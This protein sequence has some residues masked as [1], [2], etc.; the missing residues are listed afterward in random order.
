MNVRGGNKCMNA[1][2]LRAFQ[3][4]P[5]PVDIKLIGTRQSHNH[6]TADLCCHSLDGFKI[7]AGGDRKTGLQYVHSQAVELPGHLQLIFEVHTA[8]GGLF[9]V[10]QRGVKDKDLLRHDIPP[11]LCR[12][13]GRHSWALTLV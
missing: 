8:T 4:F 3:S 12:T 7:S 9:T 1:R 11:L 10:T 13:E 5:G 6:W 2:P